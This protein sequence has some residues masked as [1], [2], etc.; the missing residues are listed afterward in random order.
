M[1]LLLFGPLQN[2][3]GLN[4]LLHSRDQEASLG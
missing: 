4:F 3:S 1:H 2:V